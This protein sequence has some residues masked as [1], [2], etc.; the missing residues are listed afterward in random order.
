MQKLLKLLPPDVI[1]KA[2]MHQI[3]FRLVLRLQ[4]SPEP[5]AG[6]KVADF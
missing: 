6:F 1:F 3:R 2:K 4:R 5:R